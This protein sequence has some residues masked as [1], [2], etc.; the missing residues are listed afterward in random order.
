MVPSAVT[1]IRDPGRRASLW[2]LLTW[3]FSTCWVSRGPSAAWTRCRTTLW[4]RGWRPPGL[5]HDL[6]TGFPFSSPAQKKK[7]TWLQSFFCD[8]LPNGDLGHPKALPLRVTCRLL[9]TLPSCNPP[10]STV[11]TEALTSTHFGF[12][13]NEGEALIY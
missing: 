6:Q 3:S 4:S 13:K 8:D 1:G 9:C 5:D 2:V 12:L 11:R 10:L 7:A